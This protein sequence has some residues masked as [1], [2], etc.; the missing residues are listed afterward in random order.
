[1]QDDYSRLTVHTSVN[2]TNSVSIFLYR[3]SGMHHQRYERRGIQRAFG[4]GEVA[5]HESLWGA[6]G[7]YIYENLNQVQL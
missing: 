6:L 3:V 7:W 1:M 5:S 2:K 4:G